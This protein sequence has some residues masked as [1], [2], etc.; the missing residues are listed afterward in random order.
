MSGPVPVPRPEWSPL[1]F[2]EC[3]GV[4]GKVLLRSERL[5]LA[6]LRFAPG[7]S[8]HEHDAPMEIDVVCLEGEGFVSVDAESFP[9]RAGE[10]VRWPA[11]A[12]HRLWTEGTAMTTLMVEHDPPYL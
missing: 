10:S 4:E 12:M 3:V 8:I 2:E 6:L 5:V 7:G 9:F 11:G 1:P